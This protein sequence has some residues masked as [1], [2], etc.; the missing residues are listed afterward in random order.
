MSQGGKSE[1]TSC[2]SSVKCIYVTLLLVVDVQCGENKHFGESM[3]AFSFFF[4][5]G[6]IPPLSLFEVVL[7]TGINCMVLFQEVGIS[8]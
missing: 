5:L 4:E 7:V 8:V 6:L 3:V 1:R 2:P